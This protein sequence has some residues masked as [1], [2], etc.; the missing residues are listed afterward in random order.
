MKGCRMFREDS[1][2]VANDWFDR[3]GSGR[4]EPSRA[5][6][7]RVGSGWMRSMAFET[8]NAWRKKNIKVGW[9]KRIAEQRRK[10]GSGTSE[11]AGQYHK[12]EWLPRSSHKRIHFECRKVKEI[13]K[14]CR[15][16]ATIET[17]TFW[18]RSSCLS[19]FESSGSKWKVFDQ[20][21]KKVEPISITKT[22]CNQVKQKRKGWIDVQFDYKLIQK[23]PFPGRR[24]KSIV[25]AWV[26]PRWLFHSTIDR[27]WLFSNKRKC[28]NESGARYESVQYAVAD[29]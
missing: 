1:K 28:L 6:P 9:F 15:W 20:I 17:R 5:E 7:G 25:P 4:A 14:N 22:V 23:Q 2:G 26:K 21:K 3:V 27:K 10:C 11:V 13:L 16:S 24:A 18:P 12:A 8:C 29:W 19:T